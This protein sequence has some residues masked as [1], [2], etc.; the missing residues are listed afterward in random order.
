MADPRLIALGLVQE[1]VIEFPPDTVE[2]DLMATTDEEQ[3]PTTD[4]A[5]L[6][7]PATPTALERAEPVAIATP[8]DLVPI[9]TPANPA[10]AILGDVPAPPERAE[11]EPLAPSEVV[12]RTEV[13]IGRRR[14]ELSLERLGLRITG[15]SALA[16][17]WPDVTSIEAKR[18]RV[19]VRAREVDVHLTVAMDGVAEPRLAAP[20]ALVVRDIASGR[21]ERDATARVQL[22][23]TMDTLRSRFREADD[24]TLPLIVAAAGVFVTLVV[25][26]ALPSLMFLALRP[27]VTRDSF[28]LAS[29]LSPLDPRVIAAALAAGAAAAW[30]VA[31]ITLGEYLEPWRRGTL[32]GWHTDASPLAGRARRGLA[33]AVSMPALAAVV[34]AAAVIAAVPTARAQATVDPRGVHAFGALPFDDRDSPW[35]EIADVV[36]I[37]AARPDGFAV[38]IRTNDGHVTSTGVLRLQN[39]T[40]AYFFDLVSR[41]RSLPAR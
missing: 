7:L 4:V 17:P 11:P 30:L 21:L 20:F 6:S 13:I 40:D 29:W 10:P 38:E 39:G 22:Q 23:N 1:L 18:G 12:L 3:P 28:V 5:A 16:V 9:P 25:T 27:P 15:A 2:V 33:L 35:A 26:L 37:P 41:W 34:C 8:I 32:R 36:K 31:R 24:P 19:R 14:A